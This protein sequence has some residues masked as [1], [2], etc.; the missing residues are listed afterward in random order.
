MPLST[1]RK[2]PTTALQFLYALLPNCYKTSQTLFLVN[3]HPHLF[4]PP[5]IC[6]ISHRLFFFFF[7]FFANKIDTI[8]HN[9]DTDSTSLLT[10]KDPQFLGRQPLTSFHP[11]SEVA[12]KDI[13]RQSSINT[14]ELGPLPASF[15]SQCLTTI[16][17]CIATVVNNSLMFGSFPESFRSTI[18]RPLLKKPS[19]DPE[20]LCYYCKAPFE[21]A[22]F[23]SWESMLLLQGPFWRSLLWILRIYVTIARPLLKKPSLDP[24]NLCYYCKAPFEEA[25]FGSWESMLLLQGPFWRSLLWILRIYV[26]IARPLLKKPSLDPENLCY[27]CKAPFEEAFFGSWESML[28]LQGPFWRSLLWIL[29]IYVTIARPLLKKPSLDPENLCYYCKAPFEEAFFGSWESMLLLQGPF[30][31]SLLWILRIYV[32]IARPLL[33][34]PSLDPE[35]LCYYCKAPFEEAFFGSWESMLLLQGPFWRS[36]LWILRIYVTTARPL[37]KKPS[38]DPE[39]LC[40]YC[41]APFEEAFFGSWESMLL[42]QGPFWRSLLWILRIYVT[43]ARPLLKKPSLDP[44]NLCYYCKAPFEEAFFG[45]WESMLL[46]QGP[47]WRSLLWILRIYVTIAR[48]LLKKPSLDPENLCYYRPVSRL[49]FLSKITEKVV[50]ARL[51]KRPWTWS[52][53]RN[54]TVKMCNDILS[55]LDN[56][57]ATLLLLLDL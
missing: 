44:E 27:Y 19:L 20:N 46:L 23:G 56:N 10:C 47:F 30:W 3:Q 28:L 41:K 33:K 31:R 7:D 17:P 13:I 38:L 26:T 50:L 9:L 6:P 57:N 35:N 45:S 14:C 1:Q 18:A 51:L 54:Y 42:L 21:E 37:L 43:T 22:F 39:N 34:K 24:E 12:V 53:H 40:Y 52:Q 8:H 48:P 15:F 32:T 55:V 16:L 49:P 2:L 11:V 29:R 4:R 36:L 5:S 25:F